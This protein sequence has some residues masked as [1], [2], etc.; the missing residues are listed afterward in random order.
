MGE[1]HAAKAGIWV[2]PDKFKNQRGLIRVNYKYVDMLKASLSLVENVENHRV[3]ITTRGVSGT[4][5]KALG[6]NAA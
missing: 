1:Y 3:I 4:M 6:M 2:L 5:K